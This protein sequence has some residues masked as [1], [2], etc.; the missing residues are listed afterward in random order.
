MYLYTGRA[1]TILSSGLFQKR[2]TLL[3]LASCVQVSV[4][5]VFPQGLDRVGRV[6]AVDEH[7]GGYGVHMIHTHTRPSL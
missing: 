6:R 2:N 7:V 3:G 1:H 5:P 4:V